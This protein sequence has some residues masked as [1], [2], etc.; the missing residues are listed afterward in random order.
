MIRNRSVSPIASRPA[1]TELKETTNGFKEE[2]PA[3]EYKAED[4]PE[5]P[6]EEFKSAASVD[7]KDENEPLVSL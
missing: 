2:E 5:A 1:K 4:F 7:L 6:K 3:P